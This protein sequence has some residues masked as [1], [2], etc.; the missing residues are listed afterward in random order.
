[1]NFRIRQSI[2]RPQHPGQKQLPGKGYR[3]DTVAV[4]RD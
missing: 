4:T 1:M 3:I 2:Q